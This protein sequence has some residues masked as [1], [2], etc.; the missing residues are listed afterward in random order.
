MAKLSEENVTVVLSERNYKEDEITEFISKVKELD[1]KDK[2]DA[3]EDKEEKPPTEYL[4]VVED[5]TGNMKPVIGYII[6][7]LPLVNTYGQ[8]S[9]GDNEIKEL[10]QEAMNEAKKSK[11]NKK[12]YNSVEDILMGCKP[13][14]L[15]KYGIKLV[16]REFSGVIPVNINF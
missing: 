2:Q 6:K 16:T 15:K 14:L 12:D 13:K 4:V 3:K 8:R 9:W 10:L 1:E 11:K 5:K 7:K